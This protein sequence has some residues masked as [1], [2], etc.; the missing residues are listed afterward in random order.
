MRI[1]NTLLGR[2]QEFTPRDGQVGMYVC[3]VTPYASSHVG[4]AMSYVIFDVIRRYLENRGYQ[5][6]HVQ[7]FT[8]I[9]DKLIQQGIKEDVSI[10]ELANR[11]IEE[12]FKD[13]D[14]LN[15][16]RAHAYP[17][18]T[19]EIPRMIEMIR[20]LVDVGYAYC[21]NGD[22]YY[23]VQR[24]PEYG[25]LSHRSLEGM[26]SGARVEVAANK[27]HPMDFALW[28]GAKPG[29]PQWDSPWGPGRPGWHVECS[30]MALGYLGHPVDIHGGGQDLIF[31]HHENEIAQSEAYT[32]QAPFVRFWIHNGLLNLD[33]DKMSKSLG[34]LVTIGEALE[35]YT[36]D[37]LRLYFLSSHY[38]SPLTYSEEG[39]AAGERAM[40]RLRH[41]LQ[42]DSRNGDSEVEPDDFR[43]RFLQAMDEDFNTPQA[44]A[45]LF[46]LAREI[47][48]GREEGRR[49]VRAQETL[50]ELAEVL[51][52][53]F[54]EREVSEVMALIDVAAL[55]DLLAEVRGKLQEAG[56]PDLAE[57]IR[58][59]AI[60]GGA[61]EGDLAS[62]L[63]LLVEARNQLRR[64][65]EFPLAD[66]IRG[67]LGELG[68][69][70]E[71]TPQ[72]TQ[73]RL[74]NPVI[75]DL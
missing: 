5:V 75:H 58:L 65:R 40:E 62:F 54:A 11:N 3:G 60:E 24:A 37:A 28:K 56:Q 35:R 50:Q 38:R 26:M 15:V 21:T 9:D 73:W 23:R 29:E 33:E 51:G 47:N 46:D 42:G 34:N 69:L 71:D 27:E 6:R 64:A 63:G 41:A 67:R 13:M 43:E 7:N 14:R 12:Y 55:D 4:H 45:A 48:R 16:K 74:R 59:S 61:G 57:Q 1:Y 66:R 68:V 39:M 72:G 22:V 52:L 19:E 36:P 8:D 32:G 10:Q 70:L 2:K 30:A 44:L 31:P 25:K 17:R 20:G 53:T 18:A 49:V